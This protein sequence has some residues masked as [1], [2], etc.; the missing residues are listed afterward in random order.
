MNRSENGWSPVMVHSVEDRAPVTGF[1]DSAAEWWGYSWMESSC[2]RHQP[3]WHYQIPVLCSEKARGLWCMGRMAV[4]TWCSSS[5]RTVIFLLEV[6]HELGK[7]PA[8]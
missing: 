2:A 7:K 5:H 6:G 8:Q 3:A 1:Y 4:R